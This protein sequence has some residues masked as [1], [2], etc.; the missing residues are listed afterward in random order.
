MIF[1]YFQT[2]RRKIKMEKIFDFFDNHPCIAASIIGAVVTVIFCLAEPLRIFPGIALLLLLE[3]IL[4]IRGLFLLCM[5]IINIAAF[6]TVS[7]EKLKPA[8]I[9]SLLGGFIGSFFSLHI[10]KKKSKAINTIFTAY[11]W[12]YICIATSGYIFWENDFRLFP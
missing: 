6:I 10:F 5:L 3:I 11:I 1:P 12:I 4:E 8:V 2:E 7:K 9:L